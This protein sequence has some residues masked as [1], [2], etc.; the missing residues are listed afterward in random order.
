M[1]TG[2]SS[3]IGGCGGRVVVLLVIGLL[4]AACYG[5]LA[6]TPGTP[7]NASGAVSALTP[8]SQ[9]PT[10][11]EF[12]LPTKQP[13]VSVLDNPQV[14]A[15][16]T[17]VAQTAQ[18][19]NTAWAKAEDDTRTTAAAA[20]ALSAEA[21]AQ[22]GKAT[23]DAW[24][25]AETQQAVQATQAAYERQVAAT[26]QA[27]AAERERQWV[28]AGWTATADAVEAQAAATAS[29]EA[30]SATA[31]AQATEGAYT[32]TAAV[33]SQVETQAV[34]QFTATALTNKAS[35][36][37]TLTAS[38]LERER[39]GLER[40]RQVNSLRAFLPWIALTASAGLLLYCVVLLVRAQAKKPM[41]IQRDARGDAPLIVMT[42]G[43]TQVVYDADR[44][45]G[46]ALTVRDGTPAMPSMAD[47]ATQEKTT[48]R[49]QTIDLTT[50]GLP[51]GPTKGKAVAGQIAAPVRRSEPV[52]EIID[53]DQVK[54]ILDE[55]ETKL[56]LDG[57]T[58]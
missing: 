29:V 20:S 48:A 45:A 19:M 16:M 33:V 23:A 47:P 44:A 53:P 51:G 46:P 7:A 37:A 28:I 12:R 42:D 55:I 32:A 41:P 58:K 27:A 6:S 14:S 39:L 54:P 17:D 22:A 35:A 25:Y 49:D 9:A 3:S 5:S 36:A 21:T 18:A 43:K 30:A 11:A 34:A 50:R 10:L 13:L 40:E 31:S 8:Y 56:Y 52:I 1:A 24:R 38:E 26:E 57:G 15:R 4:A 2:G